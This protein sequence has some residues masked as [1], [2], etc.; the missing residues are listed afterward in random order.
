MNKRWILLIVMVIAALAL[1]ACDGDDEEESPTVEPTPTEEAV[2]EAT[3][4]PT[5]E[6]AAEEEPTEEPAAEEPTEEAAEEEMTEEATEE[7]AA[8]EEATEEVAMAPEETEEA[9]EEAAAEEEAAEEEMTE[10]AMAED[11]GVTPPPFAID[12][13]EGETFRVAVVMPSTSTDLAFSQSMADSL[14]IIQ[15]ALGEDRFEYAVSENIFVVE[16][17]ATAIRDYA[18]QDFDLVIAH[19]SQYGSSLEEIAPDFP[20]TAFAWG[21]TVNTFVDEGITNVYAYEARSEE[22]G[23]VFGVMA[24]HLTESNVI[25]VIGPIETGDAKLY[26]DGFV[27]GVKSV[28][29]EIDPIVNYIQSF[30]D[31]ALAAEAADA[32][33][34]NGADVLTG[35]AQMVPGAIQKASEEDAL[36]FGTQAN[37]TDLAPEIVVANQVYDWIV[38]LEDIINRVLAGELGGEAYAITLE[39]GGLRIEYNDAYELPEDVRAAADD[40]AAAISAGE[41]DVMAAIDEA[42]GEPAEAAEEEMTEEATEEAAAEEEM[43]EEAM[44]E[45]EGVTPLPLAIDLPEGE[46]F[47][48]AVVMPS[49]ST[50]L[51]FSQSMADSLAIIQDALGEDRFEY[52]VSENIF[53]VEDAATAIR[54]YATQDFD[55]VIAHGSQYGSSLEEI[56]PDFPETAFAWGTTVNTFVDEGITNVY[57]YEARS[58]EGGYVFGVMAA[59]LTES[60]VIGVIGPIETG[61]A[62]LY[63]DGFVAGVKSVNPEID[64]IVNY[65]QSFGDL[66]LAAEAADAMLANGADV[67]TGTAQMVPGAIQ[68]AS[69]EDALWFGTQANQTDLAPEI[70]VAN[71]VYDWIVVLE[72]IINRVLAG[73]LG[74]EAYAITLENGGLRIEYNDAYELPE[75]V[76]A[77]ADDA[78]AAISA[79]EIDVMAAIDEAMG[80]PA[81]EAGD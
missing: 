52:A 50:D 77:A 79:G 13:P 48:V 78:A 46:T 68:K 67:L 37:Q 4:E 42:M 80:E 43:T 59:H 26:V 28:N 27:A 55:L 62:K 74:G 54:D 75:D 41:I 23:Y 7:A 9:T 18:T 11:E 3:E 5:E 38:V 16:D 29:P 57:A 15:D 21:T 58:E 20:E 69:E 72:D 60:N 17:A 1:A 25:G 33:L 45:D 34:A 81:E 6:P 73:E 36:W 71:Q 63:V 44:A 14:A 39:N 32:M 35:T 19:G 51:A 47:R 61:D 10:E 22:G 30:G 70:V 8:E 40:A 49:T 56:A 31:L 53:V 64:P 24:A 12:L 65:I 76:R 2:E 66:A